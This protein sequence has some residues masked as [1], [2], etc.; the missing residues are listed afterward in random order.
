VVRLRSL[1][2]MP[3]GGN[4]EGFVSAGAVAVMG[5]SATSPGTSAAN[6][7]VGFT[8]GIGAQGQLLGSG[9]TRIELVYDQANSSV[10]T[11][12]GYD[13]EYESWGIKATW[14]F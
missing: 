9:T 13:P 11:P 14:L 12:G 10:T 6:T 4:W 5:T 7:N 2:G 3:V 1:I 8:A